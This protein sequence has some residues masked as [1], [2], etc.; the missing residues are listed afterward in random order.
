MRKYA[1]TIAILALII[2]LVGVFVWGLLG[3]AERSSGYVP[4]TSWR[5]LPIPDDAVKVTDG[6]IATLARAVFTAN[7]TTTEVDSWMATQWRM[8]GLIRG[9]DNLVFG[10]WT[11][12]TYRSTR[13]D[14]VYSYYVSISGGKASL[15]VQV[16]FAK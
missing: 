12:H 6:E 7:G 4:K 8:Y 10:V 1:T 13:D 14:N 3:R 11:N 5:G 2:A 9:Q 16:Q 15:T